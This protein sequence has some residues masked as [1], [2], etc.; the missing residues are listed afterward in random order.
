MRNIVLKGNV[1]EQLT[2]LPDNHVQCI[3]S[4]PPYWGLRDYKIAA[5]H[6]PEIRYTIFGF[7]IIVPE[8]ECVFGLEKTDKD[9]V[10]HMVHVCREAKRVLRNDGVFFLNLGDSYAGAG[11]SSGHDEETLNMGRKTANYGAGNTQALHRQ[12]KDGSNL[13]GGK[14]TFVNS[15]RNYENVSRNNSGSLCQS[16]P[17]LYRHRDFGCLHQ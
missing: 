4:S 15:L 12:R 10:G 8:Q 7:E 16:A 3:V 9:F 1:A 11:G 13:M 14:N 17:G 6:W 2:R 5:S